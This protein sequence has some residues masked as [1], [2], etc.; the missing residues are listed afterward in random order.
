MSTPQAH[1]AQWVVR[2]FLVIVC[3]SYIMINLF[4]YLKWSNLQLSSFL[5]QLYL[6]GTICATT[7]LL[8][9]GIGVVYAIIRRLPSAHSPLTGDEETGNR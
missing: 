4:C 8:F 6:F 1:S 3:I 2:E 7:A 9:L 5:S